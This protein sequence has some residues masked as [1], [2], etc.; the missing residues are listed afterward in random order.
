MNHLLDIKQLSQQHIFDLFTL[1]DE[2]KA[3]T[4]NPKPLSGRPAIA[5]FFENSTR[6]L[7][8]F[9]LACHRLGVDITALNIAHSSTQ[10][11]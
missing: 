10:K 6:T 5:L 11:G 8:S 2:L 4:N 9:Q 1:A 3:Q 7:T